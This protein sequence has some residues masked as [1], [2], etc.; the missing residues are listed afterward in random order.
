MIQSVYYVIVYTSQGVPASVY[1]RV[2]D[3]SASANYYGKLSLNPLRKDV[4]NTTSFDGYYVMQFSITDDS[5]S[6]PF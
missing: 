3:N 2:F 6:L 1:R 5:Q 4:Y